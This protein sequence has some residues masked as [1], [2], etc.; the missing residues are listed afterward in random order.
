VG[1]VDVRLATALGGSLQPHY[2]VYTSVLQHPPRTV[3]L[4]VRDPQPDPMLASA[5]LDAFP[6]AGAGVVAYSERTLQTREAAPV[7]W[8]GE[9]LELAGLI[10]SALMVLGVAG[11]QR[12]WV[13][14]LV[15]EIG[16]RRSVGASR[17]RI[18]RLVLAQALGAAFKG[19]VL[20]IW[21]GYAVWSV[22]PTAVTGTAV[23]DLE[24]LLVYAGGFASI[25]VLSVFPAAWRA[26][27]VPVTALLLRARQ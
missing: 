11:Y 9:R 18:L 10:I 7:Q 22:L 16:I 6:D 13:E 25:V 15:G 5:L 8:F 1:V 17:H 26:T 14:S 12:L 2:T 3:D 20:G 23:W 21:F 24:Q 19:I 27:N 4:L